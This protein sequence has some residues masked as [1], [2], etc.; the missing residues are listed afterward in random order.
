MLST[1]EFA[2]MVQT[3]SDEQ[4]SGTFQG[5]F[6]DKLQFSRTKIYF[7]NLHSL[8]LFDHPTD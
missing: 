2:T 6:S 4:I 8:T 7:K 3:T 5:C 1:Q